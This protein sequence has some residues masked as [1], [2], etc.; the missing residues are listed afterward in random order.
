[1]RHD[2][3]L[4]KFI[5]GLGPIPKSTQRAWTQGFKLKSRLI[6][7]ISIAALPVCKIS[8]KILTNALVIAKFK[9]LDFDALGGVKGGWAKL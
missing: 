6:R 8:A 9:Y 3:T 5:F 7:L 1:M 4:K 2:H